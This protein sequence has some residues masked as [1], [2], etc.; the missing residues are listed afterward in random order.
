LVKYTK[1]DDKKSNF[2]RQAV[3][4]GLNTTTDEMIN[5]NSAVGPS[6]TFLNASFVKQVRADII[7]SATDLQVLV[8]PPQA[9]L[10][11]RKDACL[12]LGEVI[13]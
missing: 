10:L 2:A 5:M 12:P 8:H 3:Q 13:R 6:R 1:E 9:V 4:S 7:I 11:V